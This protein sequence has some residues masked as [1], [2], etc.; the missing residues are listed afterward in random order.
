MYSENPSILQLAALL[1]AHDVYHIVLCPG[2][3]NAPIVRTLAMLPQYRC[4]SVTD[5]RS[6]G[7]IAIGLAL[8]SRRPAAVCCTS[9]SALLNLHPAVAEAFYQQVPLI[10]I[11]ADRPAAWIGQ[12]DGQTLPQPHVFGTL[13]KRSVNLPQIHTTEDEWYANRLLNEALSEAVHHTCGPVHINIPLAE[14]L[15][16]FTETSLPAARIIHRIGAPASDGLVAALRE[17]IARY[18]RRMLVCGQ[19]KPDEAE[20]VRQLLPDGWVCLSEPLGNLHTGSNVLTAFDTVLYKPAYDGHAAL[21][22]QWVVT[23]GGHIVSKR[24]KTWLRSLPILSHWHVAADGTHSDLFGRLECTVENTAVNFLKALRKAETES[25]AYDNAYVDNWQRLCRNITPPRH[26]TFSSL[27][28]TEEL[29]RHLPQD[30]VLHLAN[31]SAIRL[32]GLFPI[33]AKVKEVHGNRG[34]NGIEGSLS[35]AVG[36]A[37]ASDTPNYILIGDL[38]FF[39][40]ANALWTPYPVANLNIILLNNSGGAIFHTLPGLTADDTTRRFVAAGHTATAEGWAHSHGFLY[41]RATDADE[42]TENISRLTS[43]PYNRPRL[44]EVIT[45]CDTDARILKDYY[46][47]LKNKT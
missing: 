16:R 45:D 10:V 3:R 43:P 25:P 39:Y 8:Q 19:L 31:S 47:Q 30:C 24:L 29:I 7:F 27:A 40:D 34:V 23:I 21:Q 12:M 11:S 13:V 5:E 33:P 17:H 37:S 35:T 20:Q 32:A 28:A 14:P 1:S 36:F 9:G 22:P 2:S 38:S 6:A 46:H 41:Y 18:S 44:L 15:F 26:T 42:L 4:T